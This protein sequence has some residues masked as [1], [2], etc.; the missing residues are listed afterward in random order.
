MALLSDLYSELEVISVGVSGPSSCLTL[1]HLLTIYTTNYCSKG[2]VNDF[3]LRKIFYS[4][5]D[6]I[7]ACC[8]PM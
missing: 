1:H 3:V 7:D 4:K 2:K 5:Q 6:L 8:S